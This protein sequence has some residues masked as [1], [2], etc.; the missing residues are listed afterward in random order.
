MRTL[1]N[2]GV[3]EVGA[4][5]AILA[6]IRGAFVDIHLTFLARVSRHTVAV[7]ATVGLVCA[8]RAVAAGLMVL[9]WRFSLFT[10]IRRKQFALHVFCFLTA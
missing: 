3:H 6:R 1:A 10:S 7:V 8:G 5:A 2:E 9:A 4:F